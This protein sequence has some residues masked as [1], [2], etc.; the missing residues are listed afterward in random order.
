MSD[1]TAQEL[2]EVHLSDVQQEPEPLAG[3]SVWSRILLSYR[4]MRL[5]TRGLIAERPTE[6]RLLV[7]VLLSDMIFFLSRGLA[8]VVSP[9]AAAEDALPLS[10]GL[11]LVGVLLLR[12]L[13]LYTFS[14][15]VCLVSR[16]FG[17]RG[18]W[19]ETRTG[20]FWASLVAAPIGVAGAL[21]SA[22]LAHLEPM[23][24][25]VAEPMIA[26]PPLLIGVV[27]F[28]YFL[29]AGVA[30]AQGFRKTGPIYIVF[31][32][33]TVLALIGG[34]WLYARSGLAI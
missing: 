15:V 29:A 28:V 17:G 6:A 11:W 2:P 22:G 34:L 10:I 14:A 1:K 26:G 13:A 7:F 12:T 21:V 19:R 9:G 18:S 32:V 8:L 27:A 33:L 24:P 5:T 30:E 23:Y 4:D 25:I 31:S 20:V 16:V 3:M